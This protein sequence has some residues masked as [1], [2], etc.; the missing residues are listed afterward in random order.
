MKQNKHLLNLKTAFLALFVVCSFSIFAQIPDRPSPARLVNDMA[1][2]FTPEQKAQLEAYLVMIDDSTSNQI[3]VVTV[4]DLGGMD[5]AQYATEL[6]EKWGVGDAKL[7]N[8]IVILIKPKV[9][10]EKGELFIAVGRGLE[11]A[12]PDAIANRISD[13][14]MIPYFKQNDYFGGTAAG[15]DVIYKIAKGEYDVDR[16]K[17]KGGNGKLIILAIIIVVFIISLLGKKKGGDNI[18]NDG[19]TSY[20][21]GALPWILM[22]GLG[23]G[24]SS[25][26]FGG[27]SGGSFGGFGGGGFGG[28]GA[29]GSW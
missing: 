19:H 18:D 23:G 13:Q 2:I 21:S 24:R 22:G 29:G 28:G 3:T 15:V 20:G 6:G 10:R 1:S 5:K 26:G 11:G 27:S 25:G 14:I 12:I 8:G 9:D 4:P 16:L 17:S 7:D